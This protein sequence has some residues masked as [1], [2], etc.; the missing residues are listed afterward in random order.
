[1][2]SDEEG[3]WMQKAIPTWLFVVVVV[4]VVIVAAAILWWRTG[5]QRTVIT[6][7][8]EQQWKEKFQRGYRMPQP[9]TSQG[10][11]PY[12]PPGAPTAPGQ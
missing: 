3:S 4:V 6:P 1:M 7:E 9:S 5:V 10:T 12:R 8:I 2:V 11:G